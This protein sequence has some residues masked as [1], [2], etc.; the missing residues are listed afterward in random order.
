MPVTCS[1]PHLARCSI[2]VG[3]LKICTCKFYDE[4]ATNTVN[5]HCLS[6]S[7]LFPTGTVSEWKFLIAPGIYIYIY[8]YT[9]AI[10]LM[11][12]V[13]ANGLGDRASIP[14]RVYQKLKKMVLDV[15][16]LNTQHYNVRVKW[17]NPGNGVAASSTPCCSSYWKGSLWVTLD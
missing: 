11:S 16:L 2:A 3:L 5:F 6:I 7:N 1:S 10:G 13:F 8:I 15:T 17:S 14:G 4:I 9:Q 12:R